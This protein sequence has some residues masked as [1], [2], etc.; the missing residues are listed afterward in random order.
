[1]SNSVTVR[2]V[3]TSFLM[4]LGYLVIGLLLAILPSFVHLKLGLT[5]VW[6]GVVV[7]AQYVSTLLSRP[8]AGLMT[9]VIGPKPTVLSGQA[10]FLV[11]G[12]LLLISAFLQHRIA[13]CMSALLLSRV[14]L[15]YG[16]SSIATGTITWGLGRVKPEN[17][18]QVI[19]WAGIA[20][21]GAM[22]LGAPLGIWIERYYG[23][24]AIGAAVLAISL[25]NVT[26]AVSI[27]GVPVVGGTRMGFSKL[28]L[29]VLPKGLGL[30]LGTVGFGV[31]ASFL[32]LYFARQHWSDPAIALVLFGIGFVATRL[33]LAN[34]IDRWGGFR[35]AIASLFVEFTGLFVL[36]MAKT[37]DTAMAAT[38][39]SGCGFALVF[40]ALG[41][42]VVREVSGQERGAALGVYTA[43]L[44]LA[45]GVTGPL[46]GYVIMRFGYPAM[47]LAASSAAMCGCMI[48]AVL[49]YRTHEHQARELSSPVGSTSSSWSVLRGKL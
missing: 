27:T 25:L 29:R 37:P 20:S 13:L 32:T 6:A 17:A 35:L 15:G 12:F 4:F 19:S 34:T 43:F 11:S 42:E 18:T 44:D 9:D 26:F 49:L 47:F 3:Q 36:W 30:A 21:Y 28:L 48:L 33:L 45:M 40:P 39:L 7:S 5:P 46:A 8:R 2:I 38:A 10:A 23:F 41:V 14:V 16:E 1:M 24:A 22:A 31:I